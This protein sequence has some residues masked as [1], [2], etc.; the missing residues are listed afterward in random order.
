VLPRAECAGDAITIANVRNFDYRTLDDFTPSYESR[1]VHLANLRGADLIF[2]N[3]GSRW[4]SHPVFV[5]DF[6]PD[7]R[8]CIS[9]EV[10]YR[11]NQDFS[12][13]RSF[14]RQQESIFLAACERDVILR[15][16]R[17]GQKALFYRF[18]ASPEELR[19][20]FLDYVDS[21]NSIYESPRWYHGMCANCTTSFYRMPGSRVR[22]DWRVIANDRLDKALYEAG[23][24]D[25]TFPFLELQRCADLTA[26][27]NNAPAEGF[28]DHIRREL[29]RRRHEL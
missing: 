22:C 17:F 2:F 29:E 12:I 6:G 9:I 16:T 13:L 28:G 8:M 25:R 5:F 7:G 26:I 15:R 10:R 3:W 18:F 20:A 24:L 1:T 4:M 21:I 11:K 27:A 19:F 23:R 14:Y